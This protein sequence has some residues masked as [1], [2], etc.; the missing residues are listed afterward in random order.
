MARLI[1]AEIVV[2]AADVPEADGIVVAG[3]AAVADIM[4]DTV[5]TAVGAEHRDSDPCSAPIGVGPGQSNLLAELETAPKQTAIF[6]TA[7][8]LTLVAAFL[9]LCL[10]VWIAETF[11]NPRTQAF[12]LSIRISI[13]QHASHVM[14]QAMVAF[15]RLGEPGV[16]IGA[17][18]TIG[19]FLWLRRYRAALWMVISL[20]GAALLN[21][22]LKLAF[23]RLRPLA[24]FGP[25]PGDFS[26]PSGHALVCACFYGTLAGLIA[27]R[28]RPVYGRALIWALSL[29]VI[30]GVGLSR[31]YLGVHYP[32][33]VIAGYLV[34][35]GWVSILIALDRLWIRRWNQD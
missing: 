31:I 20:V 32:S 11:S 10:F 6:E 4:E 25:Q 21:V 15:S 7:T 17:T 26:F 2:A 13:H 1:A 34:A 5:G 35:A 8:L 16:A 27:D 3:M 9:S 23:H 33:D 30:A 29:F 28:I 22:S 19:V 12:D 24:F 18:L 14:T